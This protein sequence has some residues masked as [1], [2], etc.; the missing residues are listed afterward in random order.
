MPIDLPATLPTEDLPAGTIL[1]RAH[2][3][4]AP[5]P[6]FF[7]PAP[8]EE[9]T[10]RFHAPDGSFRVCF[11]GCSPE[12]AFAEGVLHG[13]VPSRLISEATLSARA[14]TDIHVL[15][16]ITLLELYGE[17]LIGL[18]TTA[19][20]IHGESYAEP[21]HAALL[22]HQHTAAVD[23]IRY[24][25]RHNDR[26]FAVALFERAAAKINAGP[27]RRL[28]GYD[29]ETLRLIEHYRLAWMP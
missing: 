16:P 6:I 11:L 9:P 10:H 12:A 14:M 13:P 7:G 24:T 19:T 3:T 22:I 28:S 8:G 23:G 4:D 17:N 2:Y 15:E 25:A 21:Q 20:L 27:G 5:G 29:P 26:T 18:G 1:Y